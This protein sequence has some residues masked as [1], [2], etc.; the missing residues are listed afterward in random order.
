MAGKLW[1]PAGSRRS[2][3]RLS[4]Y[5]RIVTHLSILQI[6]GTIG[7]LR[8]IYRRGFLRCLLW[9]MENYYVANPG[10]QMAGSLLGQLRG[11]CL[12]LV[13]EV[14]KFY[15]DEFMMFQRMVQRGEEF[16]ANAFL[17]NFKRGL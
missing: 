1:M 12:L 10:D 15:F 17:S 11:Q 4:G 8:V 3:G 9:P 2:Q 16:R 6:G 14:V 7:P 5:L 13:F